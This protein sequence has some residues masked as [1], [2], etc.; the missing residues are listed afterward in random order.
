MQSQSSGF[1]FLHRFFPERRTGQMFRPVIIINGGNTMK[2]QKKSSIAQNEQSMEDPASY[3]ERMSDFLHRQ[4]QPRPL[5]PR[6]PR[7]LPPQRSLIAK[8]ERRVRLIDLAKYRRLVKRVLTAM[9]S[10]PYNM[11]DQEIIDMFEIPKTHL[12]YVKHIPKKYL[13]RGNK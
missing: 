13:T 3:Q 2:Q 11:T 4:T 7:V 9:T 1:R 12:E 8:K 10:E 6:P 5:P